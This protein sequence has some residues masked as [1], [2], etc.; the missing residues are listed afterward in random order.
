MTEKI[1]V[2]D[3]SGDI[4]H[5]PEGAI[6]RA[7][8]ITWESTAPNG[9]GAA[10]F[11]VKR[12]DAF[13]DWV[14][15]E[16]YGVIIW[17]GATIV[18]Q[19]RIE[20]M[21]RTIGGTDENITIQCVGWW[22][23]LEERT[24]RKRWIDIKGISWLRWPD[25]LTLDP[26]QV[27]WIS[28]KH[29]NILQVYAGSGDITR[30][31]NEKYRELYEL[32]AGTVRRV[33]FN[34]LGRTGERLDLVVWS[35]DASVTELQIEFTGGNPQTGSAN[36]LFTSSS[37]DF[38]LRI[39][40][41][42]GDIFDQNDYIHPSDLRVEAN[43]EA[44]HSDIS[45]PTYTQGQ[46]IEDIIL[47]TNQKGAQLSTDFSQLDDPGLILDPFSVEEP[48]YA[49]GVI[50]S[51]AAYGDAALNTWLPYVWDQSDT[52]DGKPRF[53]LAARD[54]SDCEYV[55]RLSA[56]E[57]AG[58]TYEKIS[59]ELYNSVD[60]QYT[61]AKKEARY[62]SSAD[63]AAL[64]DSASI[65]A[66]YRRDKFLK[67][68]DGDATR[69]DY[70]GRRYIQYHKDRLTRATI[71]IK[72]FAATKEGGKIP[73][74][75]VRAGQRI[76]LLNTGEIFFIRHTSYDAETQTVRIS[77]DMPADNVAMLFVQRERGMGPLANG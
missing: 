14:I 6:D 64:A 4:V 32:P 54:V 67:L 61:N 34:Y 18:Y 47:L 46:L 42:V 28:R 51:I 40:T 43:Y 36:H 71:T 72:G 22:A 66:E 31:G 9:F 65:A 1:Q 63:N 52:S 59:S 23:V 2:Y 70:L 58:L 73:A 45:N 75:R 16:S 69:A 3:L 13:A 49:A 35:V 60:V 77:P 53:V 39:Q 7:T 68:G 30:T 74:N 11:Q 38:E 5:D 20:T 76:K 17:D 37:R 57:L 33:V 8:G 26:I 29:E 48:Q 56:R 27:T 50:E 10:S 12:S 41:K 44:G 25:G 55:V 19:G 62:R 21:P 24:I 15:R